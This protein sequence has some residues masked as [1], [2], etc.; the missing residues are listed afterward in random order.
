[1]SLFKNL[2][3][4]PCAE[5]DEELKEI[6]YEFGCFG[7]G[8]TKDDFDNVLEMLYDWGDT[9]LHPIGQWPPNRLCW[10]GTF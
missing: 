9:E 5:Y 7:E 6:I 2:K 3:L 10:I 1:M 4:S 8:D